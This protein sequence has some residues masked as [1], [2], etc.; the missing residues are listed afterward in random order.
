MRMLT[1]SVSE[2]TLR[3][4]RGLTKR[5]SFVQTLPAWLN[6]TEW[7]VMWSLRENMCRASCKR[8][9]VGT[10]PE[11]HKFQS[12]QS[13]SRESTYWRSL[14]DMFCSIFRAIK[15]ALRTSASGTRSLY[16]YTEHVRLFFVFSV[17]NEERI[18]REKIVS[19]CLTNNERRWWSSPKLF[20]AKCGI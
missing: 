5:Q 19:K 14:L 15:L 16:F 11:F 18:A 2:S 17:P 4:S 3:C 7:E 10:T 20:G 9:A 6:K 12:P 1:R 8:R 13:V